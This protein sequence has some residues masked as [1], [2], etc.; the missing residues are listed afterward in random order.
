MN[1]ESNYRN[2]WKTIFII[3]TALIGGFLLSFLGFGLLWSGIPWLV[4]LVMILPFLFLSYGILRWSRGAIGLCAFIG[5]GA[6]PLGLLIIQFRDTNGSHLMP[7]LIV[8]GWLIGIC[9]GC[10]WGKL[11]QKSS[12]NSS[13]DVVSP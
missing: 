4:Q 13:K 2:H 8:T 10:Y 9:A 6:A 5:I 3:L 11:S 12:V 1:E 7:I